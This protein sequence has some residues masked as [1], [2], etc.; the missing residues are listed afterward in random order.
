MVVFGNTVIVLYLLFPKS[1][2]F[3]S[4]IFLHGLEFQKCNRWDTFRRTEKIILKFLPLIQI[5]RREFCIR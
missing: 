1:Q 3:G 2:P 5:M 4:W